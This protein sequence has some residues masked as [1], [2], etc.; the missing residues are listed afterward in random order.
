MSDEFI[1]KLYPLNSLE[2]CKFA[3]LCRLYQSNSRVWSAISLPSDHMSLLALH[4]LGAYTHSVGLMMSLVSSHVRSVKEHT[5]FSG[6]YIFRSMQDMNPIDVARVFN[7]LIDSGKE[8]LIR[9]S[10]ALL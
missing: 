2:P 7:H 3:H 8:Y 1:V 10:K 5:F 9:N 6:A 4:R